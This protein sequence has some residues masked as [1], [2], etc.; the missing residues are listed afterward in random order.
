VITAVYDGSDDRVAGEIVIVDDEID[1]LNG[2]KIGAE[3]K[4]PW[5]VRLEVM[6]SLTQ[7][8]D[9]KYEYTLDAWIRQCDSAA[10]ANIFG[11]FYE[12]TRIEYA[13][14]PHL[15]QTIELSDAEHTDFNRFLFGFTGATGA[16]TYQ[17]A[18]IGDFKL[19]FIRPNDPI[20]G[21]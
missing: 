2:N 18:L 3:P 9:S 17:T 13:A 12:D 4:G 11:T 8:A 21:D 15:A 6:R 14:T 10:C 5:A 7:N 16:G 20:A 1:W 19:S